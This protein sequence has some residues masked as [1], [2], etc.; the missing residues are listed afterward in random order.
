MPVSLRINLLDLCNGIL[1]H[2]DGVAVE[3][4]ADVYPQDDDM[5]YTWA[6]TDVAGSPTTAPEGVSLSGAALTALESAQVGAKFYITCT[7]SDSSY[8]AV[9]REFTVI[10]G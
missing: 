3:L 6:I 4:K 2:N 5:T 8:K 7:P 10:E 1:E 9:T